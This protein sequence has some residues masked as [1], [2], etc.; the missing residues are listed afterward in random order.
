MRFQKKQK[1]KQKHR[2]VNL[3]YTVPPSPLF[4]YHLL[5]VLLL[6]DVHHHQAL[7]DQAEAHVVLGVAELYR[8]VG[9]RGAR[10]LHVQQALAVLD[11]P[12]DAVHHVGTGILLEKDAD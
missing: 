11:V 9:A 10:V 8:D 12:H 6:A 7:L 5:Q 2:K 4:T 3:L 1:Q